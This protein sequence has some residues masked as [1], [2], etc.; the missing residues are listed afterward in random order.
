MSGYTIKT[1]V[2]FCLKIFFTFTNCVDP[3]EIQHYAAFH[4]GLRCLQRYSF[5]GFP[6]TNVVDKTHTTITTPPT[7][8]TVTYIRSLTETS[9]P[10][11]HGWSTLEWLLT[12]F[13]LLIFDGSAVSIRIYMEP[14]EVVEY[15][16]SGRH[17]L[18]TMANFL[19]QAC[20]IGTILE[21]GLPKINQ[22]FPTC[23]GWHMQMITKRCQ[24]SPRRDISSGSA[25]LAT[26]TNSR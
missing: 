13:Q 18:I 14:S 17:R 2:L 24:F 10:L 26:I 21:E 8:E 9:W 5:R 3:D 6:N 22:R 23:I 16:V 7:K 25:L 11:D 20:I 15:A 12:R 1:I 19:W 4:L